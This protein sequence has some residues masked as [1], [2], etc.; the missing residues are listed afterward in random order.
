MTEVS[1]RVI[2]NLVSETARSSTLNMIEVGR[3]KKKHLYS[4]EKRISM[5]SVAEKNIT[6]VKNNN[7]L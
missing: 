1:N 6:S 3:Q 4:A 2:N 5:T 7:S